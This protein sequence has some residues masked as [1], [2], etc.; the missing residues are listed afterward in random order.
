MDPALASMI[1]DTPAGVRSDVARR[2]ETAFLRLGIVYAC[3]AALVFV[4]LWVQTHPG[5]LQ[6]ATAHLMSCETD[7]RSKSAPILK[8]QLDVPPRDLRFEL[9][10]EDVAALGEACRQHA[11]VNVVY[12]QESADRP[13]WPRPSRTWAVARSSARKW[14]PGASG[15]TWW[16]ARRSEA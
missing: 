15:R 13:A 9:H 5:P 8:M 7:R 14:S 4:V 6:P 3:F 10:G 11:Y 16:S 12:R 1:T 2:K